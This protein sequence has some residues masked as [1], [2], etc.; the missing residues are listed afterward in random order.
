VPSSYTACTL[1]DTAGFAL[2][3]ETSQ[4]LVLE[5]IIVDE[6][7]TRRCRR[8][9]AGIDFSESKNLFDDLLKVGPGGYFL[10]IESTFHLCR[11]SEF[12][13]PQLHDKNQLEEMLESYQTDIYA[14]ARDKVTEI[15]SAPI[16][17]ALSETVRAKLDDI[18]ERATDELA[19]D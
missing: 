15:L 11:S 2:Y 19:K 13:Q 10:D 12:Y 7:I 5:Q 9:A 16:Q 6:E 1:D 14:R 4:L 3:F 17:N 8:L 18:L